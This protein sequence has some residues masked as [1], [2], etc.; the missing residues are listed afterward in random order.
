MAQRPTA[1]FNIDPNVTSG[2]DLANILNR[3]Q[4]AIDSGNSGASR[5]PYLDAGGLWVRE[6]DPMRLYLYDGTTDRELYNTTDG[7]VGGS[8]W[9]D[10]GNNIYY[11]EGN[12]GIGVDSPQNTLHLK[13][14]IQI[15][16]PSGNHTWIDKQ[17]A[18]LIIHAGNGSELELKADTFKLETPTEAERLTID[19]SGNVGIGM[20][21]LRQ[22]SEAKEQLAEWKSQFDARLKAD[23]KADKKAVTLEITDDAF[24]VLP[25]E[26]KL[27]EWMET[28][29]A[30]DKLQV[31]GNATFSGTV[32]AGTS[33]FST[34]DIGGATGPTLTGDL[35]ISVT[36]ARNGNR[37]FPST[38]ALMDLGSSS[39]RFK[40]GYFAGQVVTRSGISIGTRDLIETLHTLR[41]L[42]TRVPLRD[43]GTPSATLSVVLLR[44]LK[45][46]KPRLRKPRLWLLKSNG[47]GGAVR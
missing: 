18:A 16:S 42:R 14:A 26:D 35:G 1:D 8:Q 19:A 22:A 46:S 31:A 32:S 17:D 34:S 4:D 3:F 11:N 44:N 12:V 30:G 23:P 15:E 21:P 20:T 39:H 36:M 13:S 40:H 33:T 37:F 28:R 47:G 25:T 2:T 6:G 24:E 27:A 9:K 41:A 29:A 45:Q 43:S 5:P 38:D 10:N 7:L